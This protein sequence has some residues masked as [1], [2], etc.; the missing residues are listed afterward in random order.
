[1]I[2]AT[3]CRAPARFGSLAAAVALFLSTTLGCGGAGGLMT[4]A[5][6]SE[7]A[8]LVAL[9]VLD[10]EGGRP[11]PLPARLGILTRGTEG[12]K[13]RFIDDAD[14]NVFHKAM[15]YGTRGAAAGVLT[16][17]GSSAAVKLW[18]PDGTVNTLWQE[19]F[20]GSFSRMRDAEVGD[21]YGDGRDAIAVATHDQGIVAVLHPNDA[22]GFDVTELDREADTIVHEIELGDL[23]GDGVVEIYATPTAPNQV[24]GTAQPGKV[25]RYVPALGPARVE[26]ADLGRRHAKEILVAD[27]D[28]DGRDELYVSV[29]AV[30]GGRVEIRRYVADTD[31]SSGE[32]IATLDDRLCRFLTAG[33]VDDDGGKEIVAATAKSG[34]WLLRPGE[35]GWSKELID[36][37]SSGFEHASILLDLDEDGRDELYV[38]SD[39][40]GEL[41][42]YTFDGT[43]WQHEVLLKYTDGL[44]R[45]TWNIMPAPA[46]LLPDGPE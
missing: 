43:S 37:G 35:D 44:D 30:A 10:T 27:I 12:W 45:F 23:D 2:L 33:D 16:L 15:A 8:L 25:V 39:E 20:G 17:G 36:A 1:M 32:L 6:A 31:P 38:A 19:D 5:D 18:R 7:P 21:I 34:L 46:S 14:S 3:R 13:H 40:Q 28:D 26:V 9:A 24:D 22:G 11:R 42:R 41:R 29:E 4:G